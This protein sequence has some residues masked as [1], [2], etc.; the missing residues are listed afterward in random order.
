MTLNALIK[1]RQRALFE[2]WVRNPLVQVQV[3]HPEYLGRLVFLGDFDGHRRNRAGGEAKPEERRHRQQ[4][5]QSRCEHQRLGPGGLFVLSEGL[6]G[7]SSNRS[8]A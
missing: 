3:E 8:T 1:R 5:R 2:A 4:T 6:A 7:I